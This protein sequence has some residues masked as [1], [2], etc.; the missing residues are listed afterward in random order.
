MRR[1]KADRVCLMINSQRRSYGYT[2]GREVYCLMDREAPLEASAL[3][4]FAPARPN[5]VRGAQR[6]GADG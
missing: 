5:A 6:Q 1:R 4:E 2:T 3:R